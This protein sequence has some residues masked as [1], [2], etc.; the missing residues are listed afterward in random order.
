M[1]GA[2]WPESMLSEGKQVF[3]VLRGD[4]RAQLLADERGQ[5]E[6]P[7]LTVDAAEPPSIRLTSDDDEP[8]PGSERAPTM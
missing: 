7:E 6:R 1:A 4:E 3:G 2:S 5:Q 8:A